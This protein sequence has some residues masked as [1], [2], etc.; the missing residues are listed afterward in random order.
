MPPLPTL[1]E[2]EAAAVIVHATMLPTPQISWPLLNARAG[3]E[4]WVKHENH[5]PLGAFKVRGGLVF[6]EALKRT[7]PGLRGVVAATRGNHGQ[8]AA[9]AA[10]QQR[11]EKCRDA[12]PRRRVDRARRGFSGGL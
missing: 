1:A 4:V 3:G 12:R 11:G 5:T 10:R 9:F 7:Q 6:F 8:S 2:I